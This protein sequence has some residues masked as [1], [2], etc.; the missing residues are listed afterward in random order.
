MDEQPARN[1]VAIRVLDRDGIGED[2]TVSKQVQVVASP[3]AMNGID[4][5]NLVATASARNS[6]MSERVGKLF[7]EKVGSGAQA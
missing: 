1:A 3:T 4:Q 7:C 6:L 5:D 2:R